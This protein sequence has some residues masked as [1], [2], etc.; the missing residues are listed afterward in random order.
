MPRV[1]VQQADPAALTDHEAS[2]PKRERQIARLRG[3]DRAV[4]D[5]G[6]RASEQHERGE[7]RPMSLDSQV[8]GTFPAARQVLPERPDH[9]R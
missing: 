6:Q 4:D 9:G 7:R 3:R 2:V 5:I 8:L 1:T